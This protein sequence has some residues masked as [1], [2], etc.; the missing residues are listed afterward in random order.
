MPDDS[1]IGYNLNM[2]KYGTNEINYDHILAD[3]GHMFDLDQPVITPNGTEYM[4]GVRTG[5]C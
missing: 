5:V 2:V 3:Y 1:T 4:G